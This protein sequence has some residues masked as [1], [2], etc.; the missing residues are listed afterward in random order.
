MSKKITPQ[1]YVSTF[2][3][4]A[5]ELEWCDL[6]GMIILLENTV[7]SKPV[8]ITD[9]ELELLTLKLEVFEAEKASRVF[10]S[11]DFEYFMNRDFDILGD[12]SY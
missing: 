11:F 7:I 6:A 5:A 8:E 4:Q 3:K 10:D 2:E 1:E 12:D 9:K